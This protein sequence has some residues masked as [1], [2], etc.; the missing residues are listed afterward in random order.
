MENTALREVLLGADKNDLVELLVTLSAQHPKTE[1]RVTSWC[2]KALK[3]TDSQQKEME[4]LSLFGRMLPYISTLNAVSGLGYGEEDEMD[5][6]LEK[7]QELIKTGSISWETRKDIFDVLFECYLHQPR[8]YEDSFLELM[9]NLCQSPNEKLFFIELL[10][11]HGLESQADYFE[12]QL[13]A[14]GQMPQ[15]EPA[16]TGPEM[17]AVNGIRLEPM[18]NNPSYQIVSEP[19][20]PEGDEEDAGEEGEEEKDSEALKEELVKALVGDEREPIIETG[21]AFYLDARRRQDTDDMFFGLTSLG[22]VVQNA[23]EYR[24][25]LEEAKASLPEDELYTLILETL[26]GDNTVKIQERLEVL[27]DMNLDQPVLG[28]VSE[29][30]F[31]TD[32]SYPDSDFRFTSRLAKKYPEEI[33]QIYKNNFASSI[34][35]MDK[36]GDQ[37]A[38]KILAQIYKI[39]QDTGQE[40]LWR[41]YI[42]KIREVHSQRTY[43]ID[44]IESL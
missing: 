3:L 26:E 34:I 14:S 43:F 1:T 15:P 35:Q 30:P 25:L 22:E 31:T 19:V 21:R 27:L 6:L 33:I 9:D 36:A 11:Q 41:A 24:E 7:M 23:R 13:K 32:G 37:M 12:Y 18:H 8:N 39:R 44:L 2:R 28:Y 38:A 5:P 40:S 16:K 42:K 17:P 20:C 29:V 4:V 10:R